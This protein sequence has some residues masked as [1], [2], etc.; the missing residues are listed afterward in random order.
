MAISYQI[1]VERHRGQ[2]ECHSS[3]GKG[4]CFVIEIPLDQT[5]VEASVA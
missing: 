3:K 5:P 1:V 2:L 4:T